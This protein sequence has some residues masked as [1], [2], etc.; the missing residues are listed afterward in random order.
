[1]LTLDMW[2]CRHIQY[3][4]IYWIHFAHVLL[5][6]SPKFQPHMVHMPAMQSSFLIDCSMCDW[7]SHYSWE[8]CCLN[9]V[10]RLCRLTLAEE[11]IVLWV[12]TILS[13]MATG[14]WKRRLLLLR[15]Y[16]KIQFVAVHEHRRLSLACLV[17]MIDVD[18]VLY[19]QCA[20]QALSKD[21]PSLEGST[22]GWD[23]DRF[24]SWWGLIIHYNRCACACVHFFCVGD[25]V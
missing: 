5:A 23:F 11:T 24:G 25:K 9:L 17:V 6:R 8:F 15:W 14:P 21:W 7:L 20:G 1:M 13:L 22:A 10:L 12:V 2:V 3:T 4:Q 18:A 16:L 19:I